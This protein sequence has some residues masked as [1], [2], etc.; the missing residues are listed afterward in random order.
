VISHIAVGRPDSV[1]AER[2]GFEPPVELLTLRRFSKPWMTVPGRT[3]A[4]HYVFPSAIEIRHL[5]PVSGPIRACPKPP[6]LL[7]NWLSPLANH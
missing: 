7:T 5:A 2:G 4:Y 6:V 1:M 3:F